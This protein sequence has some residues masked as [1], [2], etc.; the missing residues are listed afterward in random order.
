MYPT[1]DRP[2]AGVFV[3]RQVSA[4]RALGHHVD[5]AVV[6][7]WRTKRAYA[8][9]LGELARRS[10]RGYDV[11]HAHYGLT[12]L[13]AA[14][15]RPP[16]VVTLHGSDALVGRI[17]PFLS[18]LACR[19]A[20]AI[21]AVSPPIAA[22]VAGIRRRGVGPRVPVHVIPCGVDMERFRS[23]GRGAARAALALDP[24]HR[25]VLFPFDPARP[26]KRAD[27]ARAVVRAL[28]AT[29]PTV[30]LL[31]ASG[32]PHAEMPLYYAAA[33][34]MLLCSDSEGSPTSVKES[35]ACDTPVVSVDVGGVREMLDG[36]RGAAVCDRDVPALAAATRRV[37]DDATPF[38][39]RHAAARF[40]E[41]V[42]AQ[43]ITELYGLLLGRRGVG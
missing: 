29:D 15:V 27:I 36:V 12:G 32:I 41:R 8:A 26:V 40:D 19:R 14:F 37:L 17:Q 13:A 34:V 30:E 35:L 18:R 25:Y 1:A 20:A 33:D 31:V 24:T 39:G 11:V 9:A 43:R 22:R 23:I 7:G 2:V 21:I 4:L 5:V 28:R 3:E 38:E 6:D 10:R 16:L 42:L